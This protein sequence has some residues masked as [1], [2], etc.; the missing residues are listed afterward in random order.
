[1]TLCFK[2]W[3]SDDGEDT[4]VVY[5]SSENCDVEAFT[6]KE[7]IHG[8]FDPSLKYYVNLIVYEN[9]FLGS[10][11]GNNFEASIPDNPEKSSKYNILIHIA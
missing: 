5:P 10:N 2:Y 1:M 7:T 3:V 8:T 4:S 6:G 9:G 11:S